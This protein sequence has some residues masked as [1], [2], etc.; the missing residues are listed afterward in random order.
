MVDDSVTIRQSFGALLALEPG[1]DVVG[2]AEDLDTALAAI[3]LNLPDLIVLDV[4][5]RGRN[6]GLDVLQYVR[7][8][9]PGI[10][11]IVF[12]QLNWTPMRKS[13]MEAGALG[14]FD[15][16]TEFQQARDCVAELAKAH[17]AE[18]FRREDRP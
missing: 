15:K 1:V 4:K 7:Q 16:G 11:V 10:K 12:S 13:H 9:H 5:L 14:Y 2:Y 8:R 17:A 18:A 6:C 3:N